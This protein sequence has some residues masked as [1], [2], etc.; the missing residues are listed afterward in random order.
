M[1]VKAKKTKKLY[2]LTDKH[3]F[4]QEI[5]LNLPDLLKKHLEIK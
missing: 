3:C 2:F 1:T 4:N 5:C